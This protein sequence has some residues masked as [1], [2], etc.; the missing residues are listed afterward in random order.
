MG[1]LERW[2]LQV[3]FDALRR[4]V[5]PGAAMGMV[6]TVASELAAALSNV[7][8]VVLAMVFMLLEAV[9]LPAKLRQAF[10][11]DVDL[12][13]YSGIVGEV[14]AYVAIKTYVSAATGFVVWLG[15]A[16]LGIDFP[17]LWGVL[18]FLLNYVPNIGSIVAAVPPVLLAVV[19]YGVGRAVV[20]ALLFLGVNLVIGNVIEPRLMGRRLGLSTVVVLVALV[21]WGWLWGAIGMILSVPLTMIA[22]ILLKHSD[23]RFVAVLMGPA[24]G[25][26]DAAS[27]LGTPR[28]P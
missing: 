14:Y 3:S 5:N 13:R 17:V 7:L 8:L 10:G 26:E 18:A 12:G 9:S 25:D 15:L 2:G 22:K 20:V 1:S 21:F 4:A 23:A 28:D 6:A 24:G 27:A 11:D 16:V 19:Q